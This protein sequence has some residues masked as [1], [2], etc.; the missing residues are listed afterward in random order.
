MYAVGFCMF[1][2][3]NDIPPELFNDTLV[4]FTIVYEKHTRQ[5]SMYQT[6][7]WKSAW[8]EI[9][10]RQVPWRENV[11]LYLAECKHRIGT[12]KS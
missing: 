2:Y 7:L 3:E 10:W 4:K 11:E 8:P 12:F 1:K 5:A 9:P 6:N